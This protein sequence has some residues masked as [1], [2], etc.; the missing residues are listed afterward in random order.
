MLMLPFQ[1]PPPAYSSLL[2][3]TV[4]R[5]SSKFSVLCSV[6]VTLQY[7]ADAALAATRLASLIDAP[8]TDVP[9]NALH[10]SAADATGGADGGGGLPSP[11]PPPQATSKVGMASSAM[12]A[13]ERGFL[14]I[15]LL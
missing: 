14:M 3:Q 11:P 9:E 4:G 8:A 2:F 13:R 12:R 15:C 1:P 10:L 6:P 5:C 7:S